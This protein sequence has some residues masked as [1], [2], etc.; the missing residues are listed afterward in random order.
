[1]R[2][3]D[4]PDELGGEREKTMTEA[5]GR[6]HYSAA[7]LGPAGEDLGPIRVDDASDDIDAG[8]LAMERGGKWMTAN[9]VGRAT[10]QIVKDGKGIRSIPVEA[11]R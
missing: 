11:H 2:C 9:G 5:Q 7:I 10:I 4:L 3:S 1:L 8:N 6:A